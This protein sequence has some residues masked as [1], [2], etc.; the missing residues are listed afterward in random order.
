M[1]GY[2]RAIDWMTKDAT[3]DQAPF[4][5]RAIAAEAVGAVSS[6]VGVLGLQQAGGYNRPTVKAH[7]PSGHLQWQQPAGRESLSKRMGS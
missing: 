6:A 1:T 4:L 7:G 5:G 3:G 2:C